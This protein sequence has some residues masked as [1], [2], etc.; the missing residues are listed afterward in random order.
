MLRIYGGQACVELTES[1]RNK[2]LRVGDL[3]RD[4]R[5]ISLTGT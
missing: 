1:L 4:Y 3:S 5:V 2:D